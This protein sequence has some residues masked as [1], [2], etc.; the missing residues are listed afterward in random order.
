MAESVWLLLVLEPAQREGPLGAREID[1][2]LKTVLRSPGALGLS[3]LLHTQIHSAWR[4]GGCTERQ[5]LKVGFRVVPTPRRDPP[6]SSRPSH[7]AKSLPF[8]EAP[9]VQPKLLP[10]HPVPPTCQDSFHPSSP[11]HPPNSPPFPFQGWR[12]EKLES[13]GWSVSKK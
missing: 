2:T 13:G 8:Y 10:A 5:C 9:L 4:L 12:E 1:A 3:C 11:S 7:P 6:R